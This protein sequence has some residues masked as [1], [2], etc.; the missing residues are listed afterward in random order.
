VS[1]L[2]FLW[3]LLAVV[4]AFA[5]VAA[6]SWLAHDPWSLAELGK[7]PRSPIAHAFGETHVRLVGRVSAVSSPLTAPADG[8]RCVC[9]HAI[10]EELQRHLRVGVAESTWLAVDATTDACDFWIQDESG[11]ALVEVRGGIAARFTRGRYR[12]AAEVGDRR[13]I[14]AIVED[15]DKVAVCGY[16]TWEDRAAGRALVLRALERRPLVISDE[17]MLLGE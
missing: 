15:G 9:F 14:Q 2:W 17:P 1:D 16:A 11:V 13:H 3:A 10:T 7:L 6:S 4:A 12:G 5:L 8:A